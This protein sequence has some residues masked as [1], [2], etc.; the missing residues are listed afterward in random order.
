MHLGKAPPVEIFSG[1][2]AESRF[3]DWLPTL[4]RTPDWNGWNMEDLLIQLAGHLKGRALQEWNSIPAM[5]SNS[6]NRAVAALKN[7]IDPVSKIME[8]QDFRH[9]SQEE[10]ER[11]GDFIR[12]LERLF[13][14]AYRYD[15]MSPETRDALLYGLLQEG[16]QY[17]LMEAPAVSGATDYP[18][19]AKL[20]EKRI[21]ELK[22]RRQYQP[23][24]IKG[25]SSGVSQV[26]RF[27]RSTR[28]ACSARSTRIDKSGSRW[29]SRA[30]NG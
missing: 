16:L 20:E 25:K 28:H 11:V 23:E 9:A 24:Y 2:D 3:D 7:R 10:S 12:R 4:Q 6:Y 14:V 26:G 27:V 5:E 8:G 22:K 13:K 18:A 19:I 30:N 15:T 1:E 21:A 29:R 17:W